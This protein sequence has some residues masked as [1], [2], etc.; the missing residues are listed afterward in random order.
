MTGAVAPA[1]LLGL[2][3]F[4]EGSVDVFAVGVAAAL[5]LSF[6]TSPETSH[7]VEGSGT[8]RFTW[9]R[10][11]AEGCV[12]WSSGPF[13]VA[14]CARFGI[15]IL[16]AEG[17]GVRHPR[18]ERRPWRDTGALVRLRWSPLR[19]AF[20]EVSGGFVVPITRDRFHFA[21]PDVTIHRA[22]P[23]GALFGAD[24]GMRFP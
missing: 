4:G 24:V 10:V 2:G 3:A 22:A 5:R 20:V 23:V 19:A 9:W 15:G 1:P 14:P 13:A 12:R 6:E 8:A 7:A 21:D 16:Q 18:S 17:T 11:A